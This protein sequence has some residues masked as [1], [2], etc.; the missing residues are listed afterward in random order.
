MTETPRFTA[1]P[2]AALR[3]L[4][5]EMR[6]ERL[7]YA[8]RR[9]D[10]AAQRERADRAEVMLAESR[11]QVEALLGATAHLSAVASAHR[12]VLVSVAGNLVGHEP[13][14][15]KDRTDAEALRAALDALLGL[16][17]VS[18]G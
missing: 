10:L 12:D 9:A 4:R 15:I 11:L 18:R 16:E 3:T 17:E 6:R 14:V 5:E 2:E 13:V 1:D 7:A 8:A